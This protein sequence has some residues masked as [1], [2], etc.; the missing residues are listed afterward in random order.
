MLKA[1]IIK[2]QEF[3][4]A[5]TKT[6]QSQSSRKIWKRLRKLTQYFLQMERNS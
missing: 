1:L 2:A 4:F 5:T 3:L 6:Y